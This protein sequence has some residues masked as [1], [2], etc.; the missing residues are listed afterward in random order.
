MKKYLDDIISDKWYS[1]ADILIF[2]ETNTIA[3]DVIE[4]P[5]YTLVVRTDETANI[6]EH[7]GV[8]CFSKLGTEISD[9]QH[10]RT[11][12]KD[13][14][15]EYVGHV[16]LV[17]FKVKSV[18]VVTGNRSPRASS[19]LFADTLE[20]FAGYLNGDYSVLI[21]DFNYDVYNNQPTAL[22]KLMEN[23]KFKSALAANVR[24]R[25]SILN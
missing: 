17:Y 11:Y 9:I 22:G 6:R 2:A 8:M 18:N 3:S 19:K 10:I 15:N 21:G 25:I 4:I 16:D 13:G 12:E 24:R 7:R 1:N 5:G 23:I 14:T 20:K